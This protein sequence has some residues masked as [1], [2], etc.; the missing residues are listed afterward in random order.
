MD[1][2]GKCLDS[3]KVHDISRF[4]KNKFRT[5]QSKGNI[6]SDLADSLIVSCDTENVDFAKKSKEV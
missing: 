2:S 3:F 1:D 5:F 4:L 6:D